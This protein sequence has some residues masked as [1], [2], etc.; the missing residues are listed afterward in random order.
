MKRVARIK[1]SPFGNTYGG[2]T[3]VTGEDGKRYLEMEDCF[4]LDY[5]GPLN[6]EQVAAFYVLCDVEQL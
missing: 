2:L 5:F 4:G 3:L 1:E 6:D